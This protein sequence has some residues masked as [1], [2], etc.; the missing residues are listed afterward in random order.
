MGQSQS[1]GAQASD[2]EV[3]T[4]YYELLNVTRQST[5]DE[6]KKAYRRKALELH[7][8]RNFGNEEAATK[9]FAEIQAAY[10][11]LSDPQERAW[12]DSHESAIL[13][14][15]D[16]SDA[17][18][19]PSYEDVRITTADDLARMLRKFN[20]N[21]EFTDAPSGFFGYVRETFEQLAKEEEIAANWDNIDVR[22]YP[23]FGHKDD[24]Y[25]DVV[26]RFYSS[27]A[28]FSTVKSFSWKDKHR[29]SE[30]PDR[31]YR[32][33]MEQE[34]KRFR[35][36]G[37]REFNDAVRSLVA[38]IRKRDPRYIPS[39]QSEAERQQILRDAAKAQAARARAENESKL[40]GS[41]PDW[42]QIHDS[43]VEDSEEEGEEEIQLQ[44]YEC[45]ACDKEF[46]SEKQWLAHEKSKKH[47]K[48]LYALQK[49]MRKENKH[50][51][52][53]G[54]EP[55]SGVIT[56]MEADD[57]EEDEAFLDDVEVALA[58]DEARKEGETLETEVLTEDQKSNGD[59]S[60]EKVDFQ[61][62]SSAPVETPEAASDSEDDEYASP[63]AVQARLQRLK[64]DSPSTTAVDTDDT[65]DSPAPGKKMGAA[66]K[67]RAKR[68]A[69]A[70]SAN[71][72][73]G[74]KH[75]CAS[76]AAPFPSK[77]QLFQHIKDHGH[78]ALKPAMAKEKKKGKR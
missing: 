78:A 14:G 53:S 76:C 70:A 5:D 36:E 28:S 68:A 52:L 19:V 26:K 50:L 17:D 3:K 62:K 9:T 21:V 6:I 32:R 63:E 71:E 30:A 43:E 49:Q 20:S 35:Q 73:A 66:A 11:V 2:P 47:Q 38:F 55:E 74:A 57:F 10:E 18:G 42:A 12:Y 1:N 33:R 44:I 56:P 45:V 51:D 59:E 77:T 46:K 8:D 24:D 25:D 67:K 58:D 60:I 22:E 41:V 39:T 4:S 75:V 54:T 65:E 64:V 48:A 69:A 29:L 37:I 40:Q 16:V 72:T 7:P 13:R 23:T 34:N 31:W 15:D 61:E 27:W